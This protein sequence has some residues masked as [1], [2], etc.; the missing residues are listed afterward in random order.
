[1]ANSCPSSSAHTCLSIH[2]SNCKSLDLAIVTN[3]S[4]ILGN[5]FC[6]ISIVFILNNLNCKSIDSRRGVLI[7]SASQ[8]SSVNHHSS[9]GISIIYFSSYLHLEGFRTN[10]RTISKINY[11][12]PPLRQKLCS[13]T[14]IWTEANA[15]KRI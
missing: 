3:L 13:K 14:C 7:G 8:N 6:N 1:M 12:I 2:Q 4:E 11:I 15:Y 10:M 9:S 5:N